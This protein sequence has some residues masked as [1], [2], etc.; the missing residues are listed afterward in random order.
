MDFG[1]FILVGLLGVALVFFVSLGLVI[2]LKHRRFSKPVVIAA[3]LCLVLFLASGTWIFYIYGLNERLASAAGE[4]DT[5]KVARLL[6][7]GASPNA[8][9]PDAV[10]TALTGAAESGRTDVVKLL[11]QKGADPSLKDGEG[12]TPIEC[13]QRNLHFEIVRLLEEAQR[14]RHPE[15]A[16]AK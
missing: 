6:K 9:G 15:N 12:H 7:F 3:L 4:G 1:G 11:L 14:R 5:S 16:P 8:E 2:R 13:A 10:Y